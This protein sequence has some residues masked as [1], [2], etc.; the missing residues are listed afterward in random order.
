MCA[1][2][3]SQQINTDCLELILTTLNCTSL[4]PSEIFQFLLDACGVSK[5]LRKTEEDGSKIDHLR[6]IEWNFTL[7]S[8]ERRNDSNE[9]N[10]NKIKQFVLA[11]PALASVEEEIERNE[12]LRKRFVEGSSL[13]DLQVEHSELSRRW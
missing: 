5:H 4:R 1:G 7:Q 3:L 11:G 10:K 2:T 9:K 12:Q 13:R 6:G 8:K